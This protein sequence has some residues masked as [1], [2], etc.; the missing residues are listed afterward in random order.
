MTSSAGTRWGVLGGA[1]IARSRFLP[2]LAEAGAEAVVVGSRDGTRAAEFAAAHG[3][4]RGV[5]GYAAVLADPAVQAVYVPL[6]NPLHAEWAVAALE[7]GKAV[8]CEKPLCVD[9]EQ[10]RRVLAVA[11]RAALPLWEAFV[12]PF[13]AQHQRLVELLTTGAIG[14]LREISGAFHFQLRGTDDIRL[15]AATAGG[16]L[17]DVGC[18]PLRLAAELFGSPAL[19]AAASAVRGAE[20]ETEL[21]ALVDYPDDRLLLLSCG[22]RRSADTTTVLSGTEG[23]IR[24]DDPYHPRPGSTVELRRPGADPVVERPTRD[25]HSF[26]AALRHV[27]AVLAGEEAPRHTALESSLAVAEAIDLVRAAAR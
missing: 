11:E 4:A 5:A 13:Q 7:A 10:A 17:A 6:P 22:F 19:T 20:V 9:A 24:I 18:Y 26:T 15:S 23:T 3:V 21:A 1:S 16:A 27:D 25:Q 12:F 8:L 2:A 14:E